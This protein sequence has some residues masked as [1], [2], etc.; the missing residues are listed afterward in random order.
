MPET[1]RTADERGRTRSL[2]ALPKAHVHLHVDG[3]YPREAVT[4]LAAGKGLSF[5]FPDRFTDVWHFFDEYGRVPAL[6]DSLGELAMLCRALVVEQAAQGVLYLEP[7]IEPQLYAP[8]LGTLTEVMDVMLEAFADAAAPFD[9]EVGSLVTVNTDSDLEVAEPLARLAVTRAGA[10]VTGFATACFVEPAGLIRFA[11]AA[12]IARSAGLP[13][14]SHAGQT[15]G[16]ESVLEALDD[17]GATRISHGFRA[18]E[19]EPLLDRLAAEGILCDV[20]P[21][22]N[23]RLGV[24]PSLA[25]H[26]APKLVAH[27]VGVTLN[28]DDP[29]WFDS[30]VTDQY[31]IA[32]DI[33]SFDDGALADLAATAMRIPGMSAGTRARFAAALTEWRRAPQIQTEETTA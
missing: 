4:R 16:P 6:V 33:W 11:D 25:A 5:P 9:I 23:V 10:G 20:C 26:P 19:S 27:G 3:A 15:G 29:L 18:V 8:R 28:A 21:V 13:V 22:S 30:T 14:V 1:V 24:V 7:A 12:A 31:A 17:L 32:R 2:E